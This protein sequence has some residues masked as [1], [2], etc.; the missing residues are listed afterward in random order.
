MKKVLLILLSVCFLFLT[1]YGVLGEVIIESD[2]EI[3]QYSVEEYI[4][5]ITPDDEEWNLLGS[6]SHKIEACR[7]PSDILSKMTNEALVKAVLE[8]PFITDVYAY[9]NE[10]EGVIS[11][12]EKCDA[13]A[14]L[15][16]RENAKDFLIEYAKN[17][18]EEMKLDVDVYE[19]IKNDILAILILYQID[20][21]QELSADD[22]SVIDELSTC[23]NYVNTVSIQ[24]SV[25]YYSIRSG[26]YVYTP[27]G[28]RVE[29]Y[30]RS[31]THSEGN[32]N[33]HAALDS[34]YATAHNM[35][36]ISVGTCKYNCHSYAWYSTSTSNT[37][38]IN[39]PAPYMSDGS[40]SKVLSGI[41]TSS[42]NVNDGDI[43]IY[44]VQSEP[45]HS[46]IIVGNATG[47][48]LGTRNVRSK[49]GILGVFEHSVANVDDSYDVVNM[50]VWR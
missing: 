41:S 45:T 15:L 44:G 32:L 29:Y 26:G 43:V 49:W 13:Y 17:R 19:E 11:I 16:R 33:Y 34:Q 30:T 8:F 37:Y 27:N 46:A 40:Y 38:W 22:I 3:I 1:N 39:N 14:E 20:Y 9:S 48:P 25:G 4:Y 2:E 35:Q 18:T 7:I 24:P 6:T 10:V 21:M 31:C 50:F 42:I 36:T 28:S 12:E 5:P 23:I 47:A